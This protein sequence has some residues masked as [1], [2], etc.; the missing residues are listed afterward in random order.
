MSRTSATLTA[1][2]VFREISIIEHLS[3]TAGERLMPPGLSMA[4]F[5]VLNHLT[6][7]GLSRHPPARIAAALQVTKGAMTGTLRRLEA[8]GL[9]IV[10]PDP[11][12]GRGKLVTVTPRGEA[13][14]QAAVDALTPEFASL[15]AQVDADDLQA[16]LPTLVRVRAVL[17]AARD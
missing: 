11:D 14:R 3:R 17:D 6:R 2:E 1:F 7:L 15:L 9:V 4:G 10:E 8:E 12:D 13:A 16:I 5:T